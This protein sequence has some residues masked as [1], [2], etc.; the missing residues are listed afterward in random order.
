MK[1]SGFVIG[2]DEN[3]VIMVVFLSR[4]GFHKHK[5]NSTLL[6]YLYDYE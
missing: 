4:R 1:S 5:F 6:T 2:D 3:A